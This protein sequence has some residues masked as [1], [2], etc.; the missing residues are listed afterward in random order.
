M[1]EAIKEFLVEKGFTQEEMPPEF[2][3]GTIYNTFCA[4]VAVRSNVLPNSSMRKVVE[5][6]DHIMIS[7]ALARTIKDAELMNKINESRIIS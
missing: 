1:R 4:T 7:Y 5:S 2:M 3:V 6:W